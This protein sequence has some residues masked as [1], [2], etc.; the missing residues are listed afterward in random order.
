MGVTPLTNSVREETPLSLPSLVDGEGVS[1]SDRNLI[2]YLVS[3]TE[4][5]LATEL[6]SFLKEKLPDY[7]IPSWFVFLDALPVTPNGKIDRNALP[8]LDGTRPELAQVF[9]EPRTEIEELVAQVWREVLKLEMIGVYDNFFELGGHSLLATRVV[10]R[11]R[12]NFNIDL[13]LRKLFELPTV[14]GLAEHIDFLRHKQSGVIVPSIVPVSRDRAIPLSFSQRRLWFLQKLDPNFTAYNIPAIFR[15]EGDLNISALEKAFRE[16]INRH[17]V[18]RTRVVEIDG[19]PLQQ[20]ISPLMVTL[21]VIDLG[22]LPED[23]AAAEVQQFSADDAH[24]PYNLQE[25]PLMRAK[26]VRLNNEEHVL[27]LN[28]H[29]IVCD[30][31]SLIIF[32]HELATL[33][34]AF[35]DDKVSILPSLPVQYADYA[36]WQH[37]RLQGEVLESQLAY[38]KRQLGTGLTTLNLPTDYE[39]P[40]VQTY[41]GA[42][43][44]KALS[45]ELTKVLK[46]LSR[47]EGVTLFMTLLATLDILLCRYA[48]Q[49]DIIV[50]STIAGRNRP[51]TDGLIGFFINALALRTDLSGNPTFLELLKRVREVCLDAYTH[52]DLPFEQVV[53]EINPQ[54]DLSRNPL[55]QVMFNM[56]DTSERVLTLP[57]CTVTKLSSADPSAK[58]DIVLHAPEVDGRIELAIV[59]NADL[60]SER[61][62]INL[63]NQFTHLLS[64]IAEDPQR[65][66]DEFSL[67]TPSAVSV[68]PDPTESLD[69]TWEGSIHDTVR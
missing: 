19:Q 29:H 35:L 27:I 66:I 64:Q 59:Y 18:L 57:G 33:Y 4:K 17:E 56:A 8:S 5:P 23:Q 26:L 37:E 16:I 9:V 52:Q 2:A 24:Q 43:L 28:F 48:G 39:R 50:G 25:A 7:M 49:D 32:Y 58:F 31:S 10:A 61:R 67:V 63:L 20:I 60:F 36:V 12:T 22:H 21:P 62:I 1:E 3:N 30:G 6:R 42:R 41:R 11:L 44:T 54:R 51:E 38:W 65:R 46:E 40:V 45:E 13:P 55:F 68:I 15:I 47:R 69:D 53:E 34:E 14:A